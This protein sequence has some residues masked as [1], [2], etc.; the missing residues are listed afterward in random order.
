MWGSQEKKLGQK[1][2]VKYFRVDPYTLGNRIPRVFL[3][4]SDLHVR[5]HR[6]KSY[7][8]FLSQIFLE[9]L[10]IRVQRIYVL[11]NFHLAHTFF[12]VFFNSKN[13]LFSYIF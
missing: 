12:S 4:L 11:F 3:N 5:C 2:N 13:N 1:V 8:Y 9:S 6:E 7:I 10:Y